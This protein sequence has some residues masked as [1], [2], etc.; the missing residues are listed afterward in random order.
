MWVEFFEHGGEPLGFMKG[1]EFRDRR[2]L[3]FPK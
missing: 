1:S 3:C 2:E